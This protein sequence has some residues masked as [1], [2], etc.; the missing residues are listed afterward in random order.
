MTCRI[1]PLAVIRS[2]FYSSR[3]LSVILRALLSINAEVNAEVIVVAVA[4]GIAQFQRTI[5][6]D[7]QPAHGLPES[8]STFS[9]PP[10]KD[11]RRVS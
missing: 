9:D 5:G 2:S 8:T 3:L 11:A 1:P 7:G 10:Q 6:A 4:V